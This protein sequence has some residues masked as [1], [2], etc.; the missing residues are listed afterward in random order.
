MRV[1][2]TKRTSTPLPDLQVG[3]W[4]RTHPSVAGHLSLERGAAR[5]GKD[6]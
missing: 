6:G 4:L 1:N 2:D 3:P 5:G